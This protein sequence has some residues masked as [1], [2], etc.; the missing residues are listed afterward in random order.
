MANNYRNNR[1]NCYPFFRDPYDKRKKRIEAHQNNI[2]KK[3]E[4]WQKINFTSDKSFSLGIDLN[5]FRQD[6]SKIKAVELINPRVNEQNH[7]L[8]TIE[9]MSLSHLKGYKEAY[10]LFSKIVESQYL[11]NIKM[12]NFLKSNMQQLNQ[13]RGFDNIN[14]FETEELRYFL[15]KIVDAS[16]YP[17]EKNRTMYLKQSFH[18]ILLGGSEWISNPFTICEEIVIQDMLKRYDEI[19]NSIGMFKKDIVKLN[20]S[21]KDFQNSLETIIANGVKGTC[22]IEKKGFIGKFKTLFHLH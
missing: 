13:I 7:N 4:D 2:L 20:Q 9:E 1:Y 14:R 18:N 19:V 17:T 5:T 16:R 21:I 3:Y 10:K 8:E 22:T 15:I 12:D 6:K 11:F